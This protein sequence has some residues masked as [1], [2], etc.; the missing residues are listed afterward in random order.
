VLAK[1]VILKKEKSVS[2]EIETDFEI[3]C[4]AWIN[5]DRG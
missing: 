5:D 2:K 1:I 4:F 3:Y